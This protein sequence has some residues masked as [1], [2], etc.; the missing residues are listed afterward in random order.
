MAGGGDP[1]GDRPRPAALDRGIVPTLLAAN[2]RRAQTTI[3]DHFERWFAAD[4][5]T[6]LQFSTLNLI[7][8]NP[9]MSQKTMAS[10]T[11]VER[12]SFGESV[13]RLEAKGLVERRPDP[14]DGRAKVMNLTA[15]G[16]AV[17]NRILAGI[18]EQE[19]AYAAVLTE[20]EQNQLIGLLQKLTRSRPAG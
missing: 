9:G 14:T 2:L 4:D 18:L 19:R 5:M 15:E 16:R 17:L 8:M 3:Y 13:A 11:H 20:A 12:A 1:K 10:F 7:E 6:P